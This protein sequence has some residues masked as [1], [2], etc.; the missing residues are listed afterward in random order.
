MPVPTIS[1]ATIA[2]AIAKELDRQ[3]TQNVV[4]KA[5]VSREDEDRRCRR[6]APTVNLTHSASF[7][8]DDK[9]APSTPGIKHLP[10]AEPDSSDQD[11]PCLIGSGPVSQASAQRLPG[12]RQAGQ[13][14]AGEVLAD[15]VA[16]LQAS[17]QTTTEQKSVSARN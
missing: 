10:Q 6:G 7:D 1:D 5:V 9:D 12:S 11:A 16:V 15:R 8:W 2:R 4:G 14:Q 3:Q 17:I 13:T